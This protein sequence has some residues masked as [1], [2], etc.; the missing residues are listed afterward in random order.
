MQP[1]AASPR[2]ALPTSAWWD[3]ESPGEPSP[4]D[5]H[6]NP[7]T[8]TRDVGAPWFSQGCVGQTCLVE[9]ARFEGEPQ[10]VRAFE[11]PEFVRA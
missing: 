5:R 1:S 8:L 7:N 9:E 3:R 6:G 2:V 4:L 10:V 11:L